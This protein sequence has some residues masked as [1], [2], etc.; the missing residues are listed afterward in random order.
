MAPKKLTTTTR[1]ASNKLKQLG[2]DSTPLETRLH[3]IRNAKVVEKSWKRIWKEIK[4]C[5]CDKDDKWIEE[6]QI[7]SA[8]MNLSY[9]NSP[10]MDIL[11][12]M[13]EIITQF[14]VSRYHNGNSIS[15]NLYK[16]SVT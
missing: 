13:K 6:A 8:S 4:P 3:N 5:G 12:G 9:M 10:L 1:S 16:Y 11:T 15:T 14:I 2:K 7:L